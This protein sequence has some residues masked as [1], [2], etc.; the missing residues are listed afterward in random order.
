MVALARI[1][2]HSIQE[3]AQCFR[4]HKPDSTRFTICSC[5]FTGDLLRLVG[6]RNALVEVV[7]KFLTMLN[8][9][10]DYSFSTDEFAEKYS[11]VVDFAQPPVVEFQ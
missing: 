7:V 4:F 5:V 3:P 9:R 1:S 11:R 2:D 8:T 10:A 6:N